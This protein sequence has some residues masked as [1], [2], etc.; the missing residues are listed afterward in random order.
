[1]LRTVVSVGI[2][3]VAFIMTYGRLLIILL[4]ARLLMLLSASL[5]RLREGSLWESGILI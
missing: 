1:M 3:V 5:G 4:Q 2:A